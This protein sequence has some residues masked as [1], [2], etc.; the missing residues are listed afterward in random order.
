MGWDI[1]AE[2]DT[3][4]EYP[5]EVGR[6]FNYTYNTS[7]MLYEVGIS[8]RDLLGK[9]MTEVLPVLKDGL[10][11]LQAKPEHFRTMN[12]AN[13]WGSY[14]GLVEVLKEMILEFSEHPKATLGGCL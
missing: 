6:S 13:G 9:P 12:P 3:G 8:W 11:K 10:A 14:D 2:I 4:G 5:A 1:R 7:P